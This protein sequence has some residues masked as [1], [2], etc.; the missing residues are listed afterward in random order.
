MG[1]GAVAWPF[2]LGRTWSTGICG[3]GTAVGRLYR[4]HLSQHFLPVEEPGE[5]EGPAV[6]SEGLGLCDTA[7]SEAVRTWFAGAAVLL[8]ARAASGALALRFPQ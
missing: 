8:G 4:P 3:I 5:L 6:L 7:P 2:R 1:I